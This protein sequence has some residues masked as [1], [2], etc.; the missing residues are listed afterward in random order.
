MVPGV[1][2]AVVGVVSFILHAPLARVFANRPAVA[3]WLAV[4]L[5]VPAVAVYT[6]LTSALNS[7]GA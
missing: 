1:V 3:A 5:S 4:V 2:L 7:A 6:M